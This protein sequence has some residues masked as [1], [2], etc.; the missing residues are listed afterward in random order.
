VNAVSRRSFLKAAGAAAAGA[1]TRNA[2]AEWL[3]VKPLPIGI[4]LYTVRDLMAKDF[5]GTLTRVHAA[6]FAEVEAAGY[7]NHSAADFR[8]A[9]GQAGL[10]CV[11]THHPL[12]VLR[13]ELDQWIQ[14]GHD[15]GLSY[16]VCSSSVRRDNQ[17]GPLMLDD[18]RACAD[19]FN[20]IGEKVRAAGMTFGYHNHTPE[21][22]SEGGVVFYDE[23]VRLTDPA[24][25]VFEMDCGWVSAA[26]RNPIDYLSKTPARFPLLHVKDMV[27]GDGGKFHSTVL[28]RG[29]IDYRPILHAATGLKH[30]FVEQEEFDMDPIEAIRLD[31]EFMRTMKV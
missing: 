10:R 12:G 7:Y 25:V 23:L 17:P 15:L 24:L 14:Y 27:A 29:S 28:G 1:A 30:Y 16:L 9:M 22:G 5:D 13:K 26:G 2:Y 11:S 3:T 8:R 4:Q 20:H 19:E 6:G 31:A 21:F 18:W